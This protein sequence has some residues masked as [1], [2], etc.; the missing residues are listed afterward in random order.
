MAG[1]RARVS[2]DPTRKWRGLTAQQGRVTLEADWNEA[3]AIDAEHDRLATLDTVGTSGTP[4]GGY[5]VTAAAAT[6]PN[7]GDLSIAAGTLYVGGERLDLDAPVAYGTQ[8]DWLDHPTD[9]ADPSWPPWVPPAVPSAQA[10][11]Y[12]LVYLLASEQEVSAVEDPA[13]ADVALGGPDTMQ[14]LRILQRFVRQSLQPGQ[15]GTCDGAWSALVGSLGAHGLQFDAASMMI[16]STSTLQ[17]SFSTSPGAPT[18]CQPVATGGYLGA[19]NQMIRVMVASVSGGTST[20]VWGFDDASF[21]YRVKVATY[22]PASNTTT[23]TLASTPVD[24]YHYPAVG[25]AVELLRDA[26]ELTPPNPA[27]VPPTRG[28]YIASAAGGVYPVT[29]AFDPGTA[30]LVI[31]GQPPAGYLSA[32]TP[33]PYLRVWQSAFAV[34]PG[35]ASQ[36][37]GTGVAVT[38]TTP[39][40]GTFHPGDFWR[41]ALR[42]IE[43]AVVYPTRYLDAPQPPDGP[44]TWAC[45]LAVLTWENGMATTSHCVPRF[46]GLVELTARGGCC[47]E[48]IGPADVDGG[49]T[50]QYRLGRY[51]GRGPV[52]VCLEPGTYLLPAPLVLGPELNGI[53][54]QGCREGVILKAASGPGGGFLPGLIAVQ[55]ASSVTIRGIDLSPPLV[56]SPPVGSLSGLPQQNQ[57]LLTAFG[58]GLQVAFGIT[59]SSAADVTI[60]DCTFTLPDPG[61]ANFF[62]AGIYASGT[63][64]GVTVAGCTFQSAAPAA[65]VPFYDLAAGNQRPPQPPWQLSFGCL[66]VPIGPAGGQLL[67]NAAIERCLFQGLTVPALLMAKLGTL[68]LDQSTVRDCYGGFWL[69]SLDPAQPNQAGWFDMRAVGDPAAYQSAATLGTATTGTTPLLDRILVIAPA[70][71]QVLPAIPPAPATGA[72]GP[73]RLDLRDCQVDAVIAGS[74]SG[75]ALVVMD[76]AEAAGAALVHGSRIR[77]NFPAGDT[78]LAYGLESAAVTGNILANE[79]TPAP[80]PGG[81]TLNNFS[82]VL[83]ATATPL[84]VAAVAVT[85]NVLI[86][87]TSLPPRPASIPPVLQDW[88]VLNTV[89]AYIAPPTVTGISPASGPPTGGTNVTITGTAF[90]KATGVQFGTVPVPASSMTINSDTQITVTSPVFPA[91]GGIVDVTVT[92]PAGTSAVSP[93]DRFSFPANPPVVTGISPAIGTP[94]GGDVVTITGSGLLGA[95]SVRFGT[96]AVPPMP[97][98]SDTQITV[99]TPPGAAGP[100]DVTVTSPGGTS[101]AVQFTYAA[102]PAVTGVAPPSGKAAGGDIVTITGSGFTGATGVQFGQS[103]APAMNVISDSEI[104]AI[105]PQAASVGPV[106]VTVI[107]PAGVSPTGAA[108]QFTYTE[109]APFVAAISPTSGVMAGGTNVTITG[110]NFTTAIRVQFGPAPAMMT[111]VSDTQIVAVS[112]PAGAPGSVDVTVI[113]PAGISAK[114]NADVFT[115]VQPVKPILDKVIDKVPDKVTDKVTDKVPDK[116]TDKVTDKVTDKLADKVTDQLATLPEPSRTGRPPASGADLPG[117]TQRAFI[118]PS[119]RPVTDPP[120]PAAPGGN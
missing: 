18:L 3:A 8:P 71:G 55:G 96:A 81:T 115:Y 64:D 78:A 9:P 110:G 73:L 66:Q 10:T 44:R 46:T 48:D 29:A 88:D 27:A 25:Q 84:G 77:N 93:A 65:T 26:A 86:G 23:I 120:P 111:I 60:E 69:V 30:Q 16:E 54:L 98:G 14:R 2:Y 63:L 92:N 114:S 51:A 57:V 91:S 59:A 109:A 4:D 24:S 45:P 22:D 99:I 33:Q 52:T 43:P 56:A 28:D 107:N 85:G 118:D 35:Q 74:N 38:L 104:T 37:D 39:A 76:L 67:D 100:V 95:T 53:T 87:T 108:D 11:S 89:I 1:D 72:S 103:P 49:A 32:A 58:T 90:A 101:A 20:I 112:P 113:N 13:L 106:D 102:L 40:G 105:T 70:I 47:S 80:G 5:A 15:P 68:S 116:L 6:D 61:T 119:E 62:G 31:S 117:G 19:E 83:T 82:V 42:P 34:T 79:A 17:V 41:F 75:A 97:G 21:L 7:A 12:E 50:L 94:G 36:L